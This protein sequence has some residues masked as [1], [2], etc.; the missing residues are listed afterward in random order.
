MGSD[1]PQKRLKPETPHILVAIPVYNHAATLRGVA[2]AVLRVHPHLLVVDDGSTDMPAL[3]GDILPPEHPLGGLPLFYLRHPEN[4][5]KGAAI[6]SA[7]ARAGELGMSHIVTLDA[8][9]QH[10]AG[11]LPRFFAA[12]LREPG[13]LFVGVRDFSGQP[14]PFS[15]RF[16]RA[17]SNFWFR[18]Q[19]SAVL[20][21]TQCGFR[22]YPLALFDCVR[23]AERRYSF[24]TEVLVRAAWAG[25][26]VRDLPVSV[27]YPPPDE[28]ISHFDAVADNLRI[29]LLN[30]RLT[31][32]ALMPVPHRK[33]RAGT[34][35]KI[36]MLHP[37]R[38]LR[39]L[40][41]AHETPRALAF[42]AALGM[43][44]GTLPLPGLHSIGILFAAGLLRLNALS[45]LAVS[46]LCMPPLVPA[47][48]IEAGY[49]LRH[50]TFLY[51]ISLRTLGYEFLDRALDWVIGS[52]VL[53]PVF[54]AAA[55]LAIYLPAL[56]LRGA[57]REKSAPAEH[58][59]DCPERE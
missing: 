52:L 37:M 27:W 10:A 35:G 45:A 55:G 16:G 44:L 12:V 58:P 4:L 24:E 46:Q 25:F 9:G 42:S 26:T 6:L 22:A 33:F 15:A 13:A 3:S 14:V 1:D 28:R 43:A 8:D 23:L 49:F 19:S 47:L 56:W 50:G 32:R 40:L 36:S 54:A 18:V 11:D 31:M 59:F 57:L 41:A 38:S 17:F 53:A 29:A 7:A 51:E 30:T 39:M 2:E 20:H 5:G 34:D 21:D 48:C